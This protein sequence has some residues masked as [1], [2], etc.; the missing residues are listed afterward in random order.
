MNHHRWTPQE[1]QRLAQLHREGLSGPQ[2]AERMDMSPAAVHGAIVRFIGLSSST[3][4]NRIW[5]RDDL[6]AAKKMAKEGA[7]HKEIAHAL[8]RSRTAVTR[9][10]LEL[11]FARYRPRGRESPYGN[12]GA[13][14]HVRGYR[15]PAR[16][17][18]LGAPPVALR[19]RRAVAGSRFY[20]GEQRRR[21]IEA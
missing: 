5:T 2:I 7:T 21:A 10:L 1:K 14:C 12:P 6:L 4:P 9:K 13:A 17:D 15:V 8:K 16:D 18:P 3:S 19:H 20:P 11:G